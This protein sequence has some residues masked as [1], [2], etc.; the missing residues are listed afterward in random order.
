M[1]PSSLTY[2]LLITAL[3]AD[4]ARDNVRLAIA[5]PANRSKWLGLAR[6]DALHATILRLSWAGQTFTGLHHFDAN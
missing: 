1:K 3:F 4:L 6:A 5:D 2:L